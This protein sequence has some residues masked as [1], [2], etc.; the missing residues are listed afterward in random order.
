MKDNKKE[1]V[2]TNIPEATN[3]CCK[4]CLKWQ[5]FGEECWAHWHGKKE[6][7]Q[8]VESQDEWDYE[9]LLFKK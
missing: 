1:D 2:K 8:L 7:S 6:C 3:E 9:K 5:Q 4:N